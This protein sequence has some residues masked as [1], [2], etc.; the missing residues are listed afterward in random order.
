[1]STQPSVDEINQTLRSFRFQNFEI[2]PS[3]IKN[4]QYQ[5]QR[6][7]GE[8]AETTLSKGE[9]TF[10]TFLYFLQLAKRSTDK[11]NEE[12][13][14]DRVLVV[15]DPISSLNSSILF[16]VSTLLKQITKAIRR[17]KGSIKQLILLTHNVYF[18]KEVSFINGRTE[19][20][21]KTNYWILRKVDNISS[22]QDFEQENPVYNSY[23]L[24]WRELKN[25][26]YNSKTTIHNTMRRIL[27][28]YFKILGG[29]PADHLIDKFDNQQEKEIC[30][31]LICWINDGSY[32][33]SD[34]LFLEIQDD[35]FDRYS[36]VFKLIFDKIGHIEHFNMMMGE[37]NE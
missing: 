10:I 11:N 16:I 8:P 35:M 36:E 37:T 25:E 5:I 14:K 21:T 3:K 20:C 24:L 19:K 18:H 30:K 31:S 4:N 13:T 17:N 22:L 28:N 6:A 12:I 26:D 32:V 1:M 33:I 2:T 9:V 23:E 29:R 7:Y 34:D 15:D 27:E